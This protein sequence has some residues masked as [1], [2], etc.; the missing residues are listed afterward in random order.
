MNCFICRSVKCHLSLNVQ[1][2]GVLAM[3]VMVALVYAIVLYMLV[4]TRDG[5][6]PIA[7]ADGA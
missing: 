2:G 7:Q 3:L 5:N 4:W 6:L 1:L